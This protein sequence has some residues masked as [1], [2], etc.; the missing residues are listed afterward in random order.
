MM[1]FRSWLAT[2]A[3]ASTTLKVTQISLIDTYTAKI[4]DS[5]FPTGQ[6]VYLTPLLFNG[7]LDEFCVDPY[8]EIDTGKVNYTF[9]GAPLATNSDGAIT[10]TGTLLTS[11]QVGE[12]GGLIDLG[13]YDLSKHDDVGASAVQGAIWEILGATV[14]PYGTDANTLKTDMAADLSWAMIAAN[15]RP[16]TAIYDPADN[17]QGFGA[18]IP[19]PATWAMM[20]VGLGL[21]GAAL[22]RSRPTAATA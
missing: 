15:Q 18:P 17:I 8:H 12:I 1:K 22:R 6:D 11:T 3:S 9:T 4:T 21:A 13:D 7:K 2:A 10:G 16:A 19:E 20:I 14:A 5:T